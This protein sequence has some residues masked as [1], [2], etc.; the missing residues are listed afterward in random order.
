MARSGPIIT[1]DGPAG[2]GKSTAARLLAKSLNFALLDTGA[3][4]RA[5]A[6]RLLRLG[7][8]PDSDT[9][10]PLTEEFVGVS[11]TPSADF[12]RVYVRGED[13]SDL[14]RTEEVASAASKFSALP[15]VRSALLSIQR[16]AAKSGRLIAEGRDMGTVVF[17][18]AEVKF[19]LSADLEARAARRYAELCSSGCDIDRRRV[20]IE[21]AARDA[22]DRSRAS[23]PLAPAADA[24][25]I[26]TTHIGP[27]D[28]LKV[29][30]DIVL[31]ILPDLV[32]QEA[33]G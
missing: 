18:D 9:P 8:D 16:A 14:I 13:V 30:R 3:V 5:L 29:M 4:Y 33:S 22:R 12:T 23:C 6:L 2:A 15:E 19:F 20:R 10:P 24:H 26:D 1:I 28:A 31:E 11:I 25:F 27:S 21:L 7:V 17:P 32:P